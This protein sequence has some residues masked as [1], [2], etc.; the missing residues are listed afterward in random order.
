MCVC[1]LLARELRVLGLPPVEPCPHLL[2]TPILSALVIFQIRSQT[3][4]QPYMVILLLTPLSVWDHKLILP[5]P[6][7]LLRQVLPN[8]LPTLASNCNPPDF[9]LPNSWDHRCTPP[10]QAYPRSLRPA[11]NKFTRIAKGIF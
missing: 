7:C 4:V 1:V 6:V 5:C 9:Q 10:H 2:H 11:F 3:L 8:F